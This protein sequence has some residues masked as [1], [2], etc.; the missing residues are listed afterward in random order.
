ML[1]TILR[2]VLPA[3]LLPVFALAKPPTEEMLKNIDASLPAKAQAQPAKARRILVYS[4]TRG[5]RH[6]SIETGAETLKRLGAKTG[7]WS[8]DHTED[9]TTFTKENL[10]QYDAIVFLNTTGNAL[11]GNLPKDAPAEAKKADEAAENTRKDAL[12]DFVKSGKG[13]VGIHSATDTYYGWKEYGEM[14]G[15]YFDGHPWH[16]KVTL[17]VVEVSHPCNHCFA[18]KDRFEVTDEIYQY[19]SE[20]WSRKIL[21]LLTRLDTSKTNMQKNGVKRTD[22]DF[23]VSWVKTHGQGRVFQCSLGHREEIYWNP[24]VLQHYL[25]GI[26]FALGDLKAD[27]TPSAK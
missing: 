16:E 17:E 8:A 23:G 21:R 7:A 27:A 3:A 20:P 5:F 26:Q 13:F 10:A 25:D 12:M 4:A 9:P 22:G 11:S 15:G 1:R 24:T 19:K 18:G 6:S 2:F 14:I